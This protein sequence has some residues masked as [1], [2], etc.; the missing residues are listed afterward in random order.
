MV[1]IHSPRPS[2]LLKVFV[3]RRQ[4]RLVFSHPPFTSYLA[5][6]NATT[7]FDDAGDSL[8]FF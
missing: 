4:L 1:R 7:K 5:S 8:A 2:K 3:A 6:S